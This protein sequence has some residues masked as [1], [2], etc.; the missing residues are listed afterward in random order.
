[1]SGD[2]L[3]SRDE[4]LVCLREVRE[5]HLENRDTRA[6]HRL[7]GMLEAA[8]IFLPSRATEY[9]V[10]LVLVEEDL[11]ETEQY[12]ESR[13]ARARI[14]LE[15]SRPAARLACHHLAHRAPRT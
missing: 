11:A 4:L 9:G 13:D 7:A 15:T 8:M 2:E 6:I 10:L 1:M 5:R 14:G 12:E 3:W